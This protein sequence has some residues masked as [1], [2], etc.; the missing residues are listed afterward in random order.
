MAAPVPLAF[1]VEG[2]TCDGC[3]ASVRRVLA[4]VPGVTVVDVAVG[5]ARVTLDPAQAAEGDVARAIE[6]A[7]FAVRPA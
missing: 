4:R 1:A 2:M 7:G 6:K 5:S 3:V